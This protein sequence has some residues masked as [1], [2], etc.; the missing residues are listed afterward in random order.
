MDNFYGSFGVLLIGTKSF[1]YVT[2]IGYLACTIIGIYAVAFT[3]PP[4]FNY[5]PNQELV[6]CISF[7]GS[8]RKTTIWMLVTSAVAFTTFIAFWY[9]EKGEVMSVIGLI[10]FAINFV[11]ML[12]LFVYA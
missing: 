8:L 7:Y 10:F 6:Q 4:T 9:G 3:S 11:Q 1:L 2:L 5:I 12:G